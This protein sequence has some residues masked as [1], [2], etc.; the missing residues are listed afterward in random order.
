MNVNEIGSD[1]ISRPNGRRRE[2]SAERAE[3]STWTSA[4]EPDIDDYRPHPTEAY[5]HLKEVTD[6]R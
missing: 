6:G 2:Q 3:K 4:L 1:S 5:Y